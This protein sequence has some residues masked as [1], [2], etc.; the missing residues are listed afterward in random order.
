MTTEIIKE[1][2]WM[3]H[4]FDAKTTRHF[5]NGQVSVL[6]CHHYMSLYTQLAMDAGETDLLMKVA[7]DT[8]LGVLNEYF[9]DHDVNDL[10]TMAGIACDYYAAIGLGKMEVQYM[11]ENSGKVILTRSHVDEGW[12]KKWGNFDKPIN[13][14]TAGFISAL[15]SAVYERPPGSYRT[16]E[17]ES[18]VKGAKVS[19]FSVVREV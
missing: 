16:I 2:F 14:V 15:F 17:N 7:E 12:L 4:R 13:Y 10:E 6:H 9:E 8:F 19:E 11:G 5:I 1:K 3:D 18:I